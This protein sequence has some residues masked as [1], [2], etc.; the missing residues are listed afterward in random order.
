MI[1]QL[2]FLLL[3]YYL[4][5]HFA[6]TMFQ[7]KSIHHMQR[8]ESP[9]PGKGL[10]AGLVSSL[11]MAALLSIY[12]ALGIGCGKLGIVYSHLVLVHVAFIV[13]LFALKRTR[14]SH[15]SDAI[16][17]SYCNLPE[18]KL[19]RGSLSENCLAPAMEAIHYE[20]HNGHATDHDRYTTYSSPPSAENNHA[21]DLLVRRMSLV[22]S[23]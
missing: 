1:R 22:E 13:I 19:G 16:G 15:G 4:A 20:T 10:L 23:S 3:F 9:S 8:A 18:T 12:L 2:A 7:K 11:K 21:W 17:R 14:G 6:V 5:Q